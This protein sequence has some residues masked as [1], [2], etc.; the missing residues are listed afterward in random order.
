MGPKESTPGASVVPGRPAPPGKAMRC[1]SR[2][3]GEESGEQLRGA[4]PCPC[5]YLERRQDGFLRQERR[6]DALA[7]I[8]AQRRIDGCGR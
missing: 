1:S 5:P 8:A 4:T 7:L 6:E 2:G 3:E